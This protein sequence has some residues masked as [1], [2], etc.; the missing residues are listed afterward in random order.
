MFVEFSS[1]EDP[2]KSINGMEENLRLID[3]LLA[4]YTLSPPTPR[5]FVPSNPKDGDG[6]IHIDGWYSTFNG[7]TWKA[8]PPRKGVRAVLV[9]QSEGWINSGTGWLANSE[10]SAAA[11]ANE[12]IPQL[13]PY[14]A[15][16][17][18]ASATS[19]SEAD[20]AI[21]AAAIALS[22]NSTV[23][24]ATKA[25][26]LAAMQGPPSK[27]DE[28][29]GRVTNDGADNGDWIWRGG[30]L[31]RSE[32][33]AAD[34]AALER[35]VVRVGDSTAEVL[36]NWALLPLFPDQRGSVPIWLRQG[37][38][39]GV[40]LD[41][42]LKVGLARSTVVR[43]Q[44]GWIP[45]LVD[46]DG[47]VPI[48]M[49]GN[50][51]GAAGI[52]DTLLKAIFES[53]ASKFSPRNA[54]LTATTPRAT[55]GRS[56]YRFRAKA[57][58]ILRSGT[59]TARVMVA[60]D[61][62]AE[63]TLISQ[64]LADQL[65]EQYG[66]SGEGWVSVNSGNKLNG[67]T[68]SRSGSWTLYDASNLSAGTPPHGC[69]IDGHA[70]STTGTNASVT[71]A[72]MV[73]TEVKIFYSNQTG[74]LQWR[75]D[76]GA[77]T[78]VTGS[79][80]GSI[81][82]IDISGLADAAHTLEYN[83]AVNSDGHLVVIHGHVATRNSAAGA[84]VH[85]VGNGGQTGTGQLQIA[86][87]ITP[88][89][90]RLQPDVFVLILGTNDYRTGASTENFQAA[91]QMCIDEVRAAVPDCG[92]VLVAPSQSNAVAQ[93]PLATFRDIAYQVALQN[94]VEFLSLYDEWGSYPQ[95]S[96]LGQWLDDLHPS[97]TGGEAISQSMFRRFF[98]F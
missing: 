4:L 19:K 34:S 93:K 23:F 66:K 14:V 13:A 11:V 94:G 77:W 50:K 46:D 44:P 88:Y 91:L 48:W 59:G 73:C 7:G 79:G 74:A 76:G 10:V 78:V 28:T 33:Q 47:S 84:E 37:F 86:G 83:T 32:V 58:G 6:Q 51:L 42:S 92:V 61:S 15:R 39:A 95:M 9:A 52:T 12:V 68:L 38:L 57:S 26:L 64:A 16:A 72:G 27:P 17:E 97:A 98:N 43:P 89:A 8:Y 41:E 1:A 36:V 63:Q 49:E 53:I 56:L 29:P 30:V 40:G 70:I 96:A 67:M 60:G 80:D 62:W 85:K 71:I 25:Q 82:E 2:F 54:P 20:R 24:R 18:A 21:G 35:I 65:Y 69:G 5:G 81:G 45:L 55:D 75:L 90:E 3:D 87:N 31:I 22:A